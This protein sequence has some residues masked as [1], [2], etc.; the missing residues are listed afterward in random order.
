MTFLAA[1]GGL[2]VLLACGLALRL[3]IPVLGA[4]MLPAALLGG[5]V[6]LAAGPYG[7][8]LVP[9]AVTTMWASLPGMLISIVFACLFLGAP[10]PSLGAVAR[11]AGPLVRFSLVNAIGQYVIGLALTWLVLGPVFGVHALFACLIEVG[12]S[13]GHGS[14]SAMTS[15][16]AGLGFPAGGPLGQMSAT[17]GILA[18]VLGGV[19][20]IQW[21]VRHGYARAVDARGIRV[22]SRSGLL[23]P[24]ARRPVAVGTV[25]ASVIEPFALHVAVAMIAVLIGWALLAL[26]Q[27]IH[28]AFDSFPLFPLAMIGGMA[29]Q[30]IVDRAG[31]SAWLDRATFQRIT[32]LALDFLVAAAVASMRLDLFVQNIV[33]FSILMVAAIAWCVG[34]V[35]W[36][37]PRML[38][39][40]W[41]E[42]AIVTYGTLT[43]VAAVGLMLLRIADPH[44]RTSA[45]PAF[46]ARSMVI[47]PLLGGGL[48]TATMPMLIVQFGVVPMLAVTTAA[49]LAAWLWPASLSARGVGTDRG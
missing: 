13:G 32:G 39:D 3:A 26:L 45:A 25:S 34:S 14:A 47:S 28:P 18:G 1:V 35:V 36:L 48:V 6:G 11:T 4:L 24:E 38:P 17:I 42:Q 15:V 27:R 21:A 40:D 41:F 46:A 37:A 16:Y 22:E 2:S 31:A 43:G 9:D 29:L 20:L 44:Q 49:M 23:A 33:P 7:L 5:F 19:A 8:G 30:Q 12:F 10:V